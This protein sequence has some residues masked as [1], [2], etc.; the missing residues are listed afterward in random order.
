MELLNDAEKNKK[1]QELY[2]KSSEID[3]DTDYDRVT[4]QLSND[5]MGTV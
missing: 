2:N 5:Y 4:T 1:L 3:G